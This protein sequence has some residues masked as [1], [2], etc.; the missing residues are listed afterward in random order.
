MFHIL[1]LVI[2]FCFMAPLE[3]PKPGLKMEW[4]K[5]GQN[6]TNAWQKLDQIQYELKLD[7]NWT[8][9]GLNVHQH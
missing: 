7:K 6:L 9:T 4:T 2:S 1:N 5:T 3:S 8:K